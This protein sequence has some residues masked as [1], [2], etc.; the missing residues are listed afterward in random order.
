MRSRITDV[1]VLAG[2]PV[3]EVARATTA[4]AEA[5]YVNRAPAA[6]VECISTGEPCFY[7]RV[8]ATYYMDDASFGEVVAI[9]DLRYDAQI[10]LYDSRHI[11]P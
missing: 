9:D 10:G 6:V 3:S 5:A 11:K 1:A 4:E 2:V 7:W 8:G